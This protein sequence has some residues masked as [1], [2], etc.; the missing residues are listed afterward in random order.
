MAKKWNAKSDAIM[1]FNELAAGEFS[2][3][4]KMAEE[5]AA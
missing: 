5:H 4:R 1:G 2:G 3:W